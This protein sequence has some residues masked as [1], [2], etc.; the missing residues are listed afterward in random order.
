M[1][2]FFFLCYIVLL[3][4]LNIRDGTQ[5]LKRLFKLLEMTEEGQAQ[6]DCQVIKQAFVKVLRKVFMSG[7][8]S[9]EVAYQLL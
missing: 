8:G 2:Q 7:R 4:K 1:G 6:E 5:L 3:S 9:K